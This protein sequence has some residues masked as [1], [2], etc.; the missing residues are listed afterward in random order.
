MS[1]TVYVDG[2]AGFWDQNTG[3]FVPYRN[4]YGSGGGQGRAN[5]F[6]GQGRGNYDNQ[7]AKSRDYKKHSGAKVGVNQKGSRKGEKHI[8]FWNYSKQRG[9]IT[10]IGTS[11][12]GTKTHESKSGRKW[13]NWMVVLQ[14][15]RTFQEWKTSGLYD[16]TTGKLIINSMGWVVNPKAPRGGYAG[17]FTN[18]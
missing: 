2:K 1:K 15:K 4:Q 8:T 17:T 6:G 13:Q 7:Q 14:N 16:L 10:G 18:K 3:A 12:S 5:G 11:Y 9:L